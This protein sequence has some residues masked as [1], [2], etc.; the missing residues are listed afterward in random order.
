MFGYAVCWI[1]IQPHASLKESYCRKV[2]PMPVIPYL[3]LFALIIILAAA[4]R[5]FWRAMQVN[6]PRNT[7]VFRVTWA[8]GLVLGGIALYQ[9]PQDS[10]AAWAVVLGLMLVYLVSTGAQRVSGEMVNVGDALPV[11]TALDEN[12]DS[13]DSS[14]LA[15][16]PV[17]LKFF[18][19]HW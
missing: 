15:G 3:G 18:R 5:W 6:I 7:S 4:T 16:K 1:I 13:F 11:F 10:F 14:S 2:V 9:T 8:T 17:L 19:G 12:G